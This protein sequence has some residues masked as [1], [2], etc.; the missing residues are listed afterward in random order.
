MDLKGSDFMLKLNL[1]S[2]KLLYF[3]RKHFLFHFHL[4]YDILNALAINLLDFLNDFAK[5]L[6]FILLLLKQIVFFLYEF[7]LSLHLFIS[8]FGLFFGALELFLEK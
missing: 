1:F 6:Y 5:V 4:L 2:V 7:L 3:V 8:F